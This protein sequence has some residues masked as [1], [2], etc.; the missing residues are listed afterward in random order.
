MKTS[1]HRVVLHV[2]VGSEGMTPDEVESELAAELVDIEGAE[3]GIFRI[4][5]VTVESI[6]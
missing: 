1:S 3:G 2:T 4:E 5:T 6:D